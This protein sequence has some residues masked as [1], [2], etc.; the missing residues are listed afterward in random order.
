MNALLTGELTPQPGPSRVLPRPSRVH[1]PH[2]CSGTSL[3][4]LISLLLQYPDQRLLRERTAI[5]AALAKLPP[6]PQ[7]SAI[8]RFVEYW[9]SAGTAAL[10]QDYLATFATPRRGDLYLTSYLYA[11]CRQRG[12]ALLRLKKQYAAGGLWLLHGQLPD[13]L[14]VMLEFVAFAPAD[15]GNAVLR[16]FRA[17]IERVCRDLSAAGSCYAYLLTA[18]CLSLPSPVPA[19]RVPAH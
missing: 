7:R 4:K 9:C 18:L 1:G 6:S 5:R 15:Q 17:P 14:P 10:E 12:L 11:D 19:E 16:E 13:Y 8:D 2:R 3:Y